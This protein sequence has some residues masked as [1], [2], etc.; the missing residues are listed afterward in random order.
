[1]RFDAIVCKTDRAREKEASSIVPFRDLV[2]RHA[3]REAKRENISLDE[4]EDAYV[5][6]DDTRP[7]EHDE[8]REI[9]SR[10]LDMDVIEVVVDTIDGRVVTV[11][12]KS[13]GA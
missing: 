5:Y 1:L 7:S 4:M 12:R 6:P 10:H 9:R 2:S 11:W 8:A 3:L 13:Q